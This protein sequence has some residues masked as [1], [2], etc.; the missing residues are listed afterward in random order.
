MQTAA[1]NNWPAVGIVLRDP[2]RGT[3]TVVGN[4]TARNE[5]LLESGLGLYIKKCH[6]Y[7]RGR[8][9]A[10]VRQGGGS[11]CWCPLDP[12]KTDRSID[13]V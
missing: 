6:A 2:V 13:P 3:E 8:E 4:A 9:D 11:L 5:Q 12:L 1:P 7:L 10:V